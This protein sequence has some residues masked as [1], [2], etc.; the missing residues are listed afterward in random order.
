[1]K[2]FDKEDPPIIIDS[3]LPSNKSF[4]AALTINYLNS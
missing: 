2:L 4:A 3:P 1:M